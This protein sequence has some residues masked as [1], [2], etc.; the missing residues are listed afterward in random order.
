MVSVY[1][2]NQIKEVREMGRGKPRSFTEVRH[3]VLKMPI[4][5]W[6]NTKLQLE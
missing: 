4:K 1:V 6:S 2:K 3:S 5:K